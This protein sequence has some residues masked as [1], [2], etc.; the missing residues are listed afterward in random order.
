MTSLE[1]GHG[2]RQPTGSQG[3]CLASQAGAG[4]GTLILLSEQRGWE[5]RE[6][7]CSW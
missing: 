7:V 3:L 4:D 2:G 1:G 5:A 6:E